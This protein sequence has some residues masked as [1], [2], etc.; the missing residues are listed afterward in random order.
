MSKAG[1]IALEIIDANDKISQKKREIE[2]LGQTIVALRKEL[3]NE[4]SKDK[5][6]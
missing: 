2:V 3:D 6:K 1:D 5:Q 4:R